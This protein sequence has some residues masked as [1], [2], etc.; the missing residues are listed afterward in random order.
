MLGRYLPAHFVVFEQ[1]PAAYCLPGVENHHPD[2]KGMKQRREKQ[3]HVYLLEQMLVVVL[4][5]KRRLQK[6]QQ[7]DKEEG[8]AQVGTG[9]G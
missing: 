6:T 7:R 1:V 8:S 2:R 3:C 9:C 4:A 5:Q